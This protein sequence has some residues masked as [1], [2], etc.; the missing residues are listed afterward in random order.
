MREWPKASGHATG[1]TAMNA[2]RRV[3]VVFALTLWGPLWLSLPARAQVWP[4]KIMRIIVPFPPG[5]MNDLI[6]RRVQPLL[7][8]NL[9]TTIVIENR[10]GASGSIGTQAAVASAPDGSTFLLVF[11]THGVNPS[12]LPNLPFDTLRDLAPVMLIGTSP[13]VVTTHPATAYRT[14]AD[15]IAAARAQAGT[16]AYG[17]IGAGSLAH[18]AMTQIGNALNVTMT[19]VPYKGGG[20]LTTDALG[21]HIPLAIASIALL[22]PHIKGGALRPLAAT[23]GKRIAQLSDTPTIGELGV[24]GFDAESWWG[25]LAPAKTSP[26]IIARMNAA[27]ADALQEPTVR[28]GLAEQGVDYRLSSPQAFGSFLENEVGRWA[29]VVKDNK[30]VMSE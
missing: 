11:D 25:L 23:S 15:V 4:P 19:H 10:G 8:R 7:E 21:G 9:R 13:M 29:K 28:Q 30:I 6:A 22:S 14:F 18:L 27:M 20:P 5:G 16:V 26:E 2:M 24:A 17:T 1:R 3:L 12:L